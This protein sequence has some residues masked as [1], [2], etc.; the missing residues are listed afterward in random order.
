MQVQMKE[1]A[2]VINVKCENVYASE[3]VRL[4]MCKWLKLLRNVLIS[5]ML[6]VLIIKWV[7][8]VYM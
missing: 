3:L 7:I 1:W 6:K 4:C 5:Y 8:I 2:Y